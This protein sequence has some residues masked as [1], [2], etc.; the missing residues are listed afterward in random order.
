[1]R[2]LCITSKLAGGA[3][4]LSLLLSATPG[5]S[6]TWFGFL[7]DEDKPFIGRTMEWPGDLGAEIARV[8]RGHTIGDVTTQYGF[9]GMWH[10][11]VIS[12][13]VNEHGLAL[14]ALWLSDSQYDEEGDGA[15]KNVDL[16]HHVLG[17]TKTVDEALDFI[18]DNRFYAYGPEV[19]GGMPLT[20]HFAITDETGRSVVV[21]YAEDG[22][23]VYE[24]EVGVMTNDPTYDVQLELW[25][26]YDPNNFDEGTF[27]S[28]DWSP[29]G[30]FQ[31]MAA[32]NATQAT[33]P[34]TDAAV[35]RAWSMINTVDIPQGILYWRWVN[36]DPQITSYSVV[37]D[38]QERTYYFRTYDN[39][40]IRK[41]DL[42][43]IDFGAIEF[44]S[45]SIFGTQDYRS[46][47]FD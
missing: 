29:E 32:M 10:G 13:G 7:N 30:R 21:E 5:L 34:D 41:I 16:I 42:D 39:Y 37:V 28:F 1:M 35:N 18:R 44:K 38:P 17:N 4:A 6:C 40:D 11:S 2:N 33:V 15:R 26:A 9:V 3:T 8:P 36:D 20:I 47:E 14:S 22:L 12:D 25:Q 19:L 46:F 24:N 31:R 43:E 23:A 27:E 45:Q